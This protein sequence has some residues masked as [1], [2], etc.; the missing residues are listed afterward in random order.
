MTTKDKK[1][2]DA[3]LE[4]EL[5]RW[6]AGLPDLKDLAFIPTFNYLFQKWKKKLV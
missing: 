1:G 6:G 2:P 3:R 5:G 4:D